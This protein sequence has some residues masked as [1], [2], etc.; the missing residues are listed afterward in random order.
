MEARIDQAVF[1]DT[2]IQIGRRVHRPEIEKSIRSRLASFSQVT[3]GLVVRGEFK[4]RLLMEAQ[5]L[6][7]QFKLRGSFEK[8]RRHVQDS[9]PPADP[10]KKQICLQTL[11]TIDEKDTDEDR[12]ERAKLYL[13][14]LLRFGL[15][16]FDAQ[17]STLLKDSGCARGLAPV[18]EKKKFLAYEFGPKRCEQSEG[19][20]RVGQFLL[21]HRD[22]LEK[23][24]DYIAALPPDETTKELQA[25]ED[26]IQQYL[27]SPSEIEKRNACTIVGDLLIALESSAIPTFYT[28]NY[29]ES[30]HLCQV[31]GQRMIFRHPNS[32]HA[33]VDCP[34][35]EKWHLP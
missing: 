10:R 8:V 7:T 33:E 14:D 1:I 9:L 5:Y 12:S 3:T 29:K 31:L 25:S 27:S 30:R 24:A 32:D 11:T 4:K 23:V 17:L 26:F 15:P 28:M 22:L 16:T 35:G 20:C 21:K 34:P 2:S 6:L 18:R 19:T 13:R